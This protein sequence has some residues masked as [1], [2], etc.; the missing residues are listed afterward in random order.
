MHIFLTYMTTLLSKEIYSSTKVLIFF[1]WY[2]E[3]KS[4]VLFIVKLEMEQAIA[5]AVEI[6]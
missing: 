4:S 6:T 5:R 3:L 2:T 1:N